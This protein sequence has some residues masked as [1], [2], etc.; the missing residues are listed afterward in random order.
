[1]EIFGYI[2]GAI[3]LILGLIIGIQRKLDDHLLEAQSSIKKE[4]FYSYR[5]FSSMMLSQ[6]LDMEKEKM[7][8]NRLMNLQYASILDV[9]K[10]K[11]IEVLMD[12]LLPLLIIGVVS[13]IISI[14]VGNLLFNETQ[15]SLK[16]IFIIV[17][18]IVVL[19][20][21]FIFLYACIWCEKYLK[22]LAKKYH[23]ME[24]R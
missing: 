24:Y 2:I 9:S 11:K 22:R 5:E 3:N 8:V 1:M 4:F 20:M 12:R 6:T 15:L 18:P 17:I 7:C 14:I 10:L 16:L 21:Q 13:V 19:I 23:D